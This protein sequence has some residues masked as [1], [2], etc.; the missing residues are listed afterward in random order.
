EGTRLSYDVDVQVGGKIASLAARFI[1]PTSR[2]LA[3]QFF[4]K[5]GEI[6]GK[7]GPVATAAPA[8]KPA[9]KK[10]AAKKPAAKKPAAKKAAA[11]KPAPK[12]A[13]AKKQAK[14]KR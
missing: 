6:A 1:E 3:G 7:M 10:P 9:Q 2:M 14:K 4:E 5:L 13:A 12:K 8:A 11:K